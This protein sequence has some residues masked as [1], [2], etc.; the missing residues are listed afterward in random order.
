MKIPAYSK[1]SSSF[2]HTES[3]REPAGKY[4]QK[5]DCL[6]STAVMCETVAACWPCPNTAHSPTTTEVTTAL[7]RWGVQSLTMWSLQASNSHSLLG[8]ESCFRNPNCSQGQLR[9]GPLS[10][11]NQKCCLTKE[12]EGHLLEWPGE[13]T[14]PSL[15]DRHRIFQQYCPPPSQPCTLDSEAEKQGQRRTPVPSTNTDN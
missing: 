14:L 5:T 12:A 3:I 13:A 8:Q 9:W 10:L 15:R 4:P 7:C 1:T 6:P 11:T 2:H